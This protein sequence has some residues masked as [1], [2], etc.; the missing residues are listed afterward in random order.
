MP[1]AVQPVKGESAEGRGKFR[2][3]VEQG[4]AYGLDAATGKV[5]WRRFVAL[6]PKLPAVTALPL[7]GEAAHDVV[8]AIRA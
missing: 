4:T 5:L 8:L 3:L 6:D 2:F 1:L 7:V